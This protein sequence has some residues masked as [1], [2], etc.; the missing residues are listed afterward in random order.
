MIQPTP[1]AEL[2]QKAFRPT[3]RGVVGFVEDLLDLSLVHQLRFGFTEGHCSVRRLGADHADT[4]TVPLPKS[5][6]R[7]AL[8]RVAALCNEQHPG[9]VTPYGGEGEVALPPPFSPNG[10]PPST[11][12]VSFTN[13]PTEQQLEMR[14]SRSSAGDGNRF[15]VLLRDQR[16]VT[17]YGHALKYIQNPSNPT[18]YGSYGIL[19]RGSGGEVLAAL[20]RVSEVIGVFSGDLRESGGSTPSAVGPNTAAVLSGREAQ[21]QRALDDPSQG[22]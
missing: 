15:T 10:S 1:F 20:F 13:T 2:I 9:S 8:A 12:Y 16:T 22:L 18:D 7:A 6:F 19:C 5:V 21:R 3:P 4:L 11:C 17:V 14:F